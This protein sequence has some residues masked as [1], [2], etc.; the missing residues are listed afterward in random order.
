MTKNKKHLRLGFA[1]SILGL[2]FWACGS[3]KGGGG[4]EDPE[5]LD[6]LVDDAATVDCAL[7]VRCH[8]FSE[9]A[10]CSLYF[11][12]DGAGFNSFGASVAAAKAGKIHYDAV[13]ARDCLNALQADTCD[14]LSNATAPSP[15]ACNA[16]FTG[17]LG[18]GSRCIADSE[19]LPGSFCASPAGGA[20]CDGSCASGGTLCNVDSHC[21]KG[22]VCDKN[23]PTTTSKGTC[24]TPVPAGAANQPCGTNSACQ[25]GLVCGSGASGTVCLPPGQSGQP[26]AITGYVGGCADGLV[27]VFS[28]DGTSS[29]CQAAAAKGDSCQG[30]DQCGG[31]LSTLTCDATTHLCVDAPSSGPCAGEALACNPLSSFCDTS[32][33]TPTCTPYLA[34]GAACSV[35]SVGC[36]LPA[37][38]TCQQPAGTTATTGTCVANVTAASCTP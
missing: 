4:T 35:A 15:G 27:C 6:S 24:V 36:G 21:A 31:L 33:G 12:P 7:L 26:C 8:V 18:V 17:T 16:V 3:T 25:P 20:G 29:S 38:A 22:Q 34:T 14:A 13:A 1:V 9:P 5:P 23:M 32:S 11:A 10:L 19:C 2:L 37:A 28:D 30:R